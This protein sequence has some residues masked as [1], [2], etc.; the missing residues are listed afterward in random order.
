MVVTASRSEASASRT[1]GR[2]PANGLGHWCFGVHVR[3]AC[4]RC[5]FETSILKS[6]GQDEGDRARRELA[7]HARQ[8]HPEA[9]R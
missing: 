5:S 8:E 7:A 6:L 4:V 2:T 9:S 1:S 3:L